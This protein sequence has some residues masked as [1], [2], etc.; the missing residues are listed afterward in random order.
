MKAHNVTII[1]I[2]EKYVCIIATCI[3]LHNLCIVNNECIKDN[4][5][6]KAKFK[7]ATRIIKGELR[8]GTRRKRTIWRRNEVC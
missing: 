1:D 5:I 2:I 7:L 8:E 6:V 4:W 3:V